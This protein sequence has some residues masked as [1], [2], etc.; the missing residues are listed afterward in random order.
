MIAFFLQTKTMDPMVDA[1]RVKVSRTTSMKSSAILTVAP[2]E[3]G[4]KSNKS[5]FTLSMRETNSGK[6]AK[7]NHHVEGLNLSDSDSDH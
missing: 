1:S 6:K 3:T 2:S 5:E 4:T 7:G